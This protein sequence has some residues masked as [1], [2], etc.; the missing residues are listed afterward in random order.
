MRLSPWEPPRFLWAAIEGVCG[1]TLTDGLPQIQ[2][3][4]PSDWRWLALR[5]VPYH[6]EEISYFAIR[7]RNA[8]HLYT[9]CEIDTA[10]S[11]SVFSTD[12]SDDI[13]IFSRNARVIAFQREGE[14]IL[15]AGNVATT[16]INVSLDLSSILFGEA[17]YRVRIY[18]SERDDWDTDVDV[19]RGDVASLAVSIESQ[20]YRLMAFTRADDKVQRS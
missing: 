12:V 20:G 9:T 19:A 10:H 3:L 17:K 16:S 13:P 14:T 11:H 6:G 15:L 8:F 18:N 1:L 4:V 7:M 5:R 2:P